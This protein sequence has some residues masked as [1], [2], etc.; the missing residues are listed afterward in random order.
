[1]G[2]RVE[3]TSHDVQARARGARRELDAP[4]RRSRLRLRARPGSAGSP[5][6]RRGAY[7]GRRV[8][9]ARPDV[10]ALFLRSEPLGEVRQLRNGRL[11]LQFSD[12]ALQRWG[13]GSR[14]LSLSLPL[15]PRRV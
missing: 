13:E 12:E 1:R 10:L 3:L 2:A 6:R 5:P 11:R 9:T 8:V 14:P 7:A 4:R 15:T